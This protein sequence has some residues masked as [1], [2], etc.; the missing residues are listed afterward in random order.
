M[1]VRT[2]AVLAAALFFGFATLE[3]NQIEEKK[4]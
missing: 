1:R 4:L 2:S 3:A